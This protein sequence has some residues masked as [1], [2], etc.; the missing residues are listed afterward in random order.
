MATITFEGY[1]GATP[2]WTDLAANTLVFCSSLTDLATAITVAE[3]QDGTHA[4]SD[5]PGTDQCGANHMNNVKYVDDTH[6]ILNGG[7]SEVINDTNL[8]QNECTLRIHFNHGSA[9]AVTGARLYCYDGTTTTDPGVD[10][11]MYAFEQGQSAT[12]WTEINDYSGSIGGDNVGERLDL[13]DSA[14]SQDHYWYVAI[15]VSPESVGDKASV[16]L[17]VTLTYS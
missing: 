17:G 1:M 3:W 9:V 4:G 6:F 15:S 10:M 8:T 11:E 5:D 13:A 16:D 7:S 12:S 14:S 2:D